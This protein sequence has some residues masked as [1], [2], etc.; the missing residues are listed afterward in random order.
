MGIQT[1]LAR[2][3]TIIDSGLISTELV[4]QLEFIADRIINEYDQHISGAKSSE[5]SYKTNSYA[6]LDIICRLLSYLL[7][8]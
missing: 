7:H 4:N 6:W 1:T 8:I 5:V 2:I 3:G